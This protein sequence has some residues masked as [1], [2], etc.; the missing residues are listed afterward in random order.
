MAEIQKVSKYVLLTKHEVKMAGY[1]AKFFF[2]CLWTETESRPINT[3]KKDRGQYP[4][5]LTERA[6][7]IKDLLHGKEYLFLARHSGYSR[8][9]K[10][11]SPCPFG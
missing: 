10:I 1:L 2:V 4:A 3:Q 11:A 9:G 5:I 8:A 7:S 6:W